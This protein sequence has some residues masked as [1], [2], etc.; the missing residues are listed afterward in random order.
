MY[1]GIHAWLTCNLSAL[2]ALEVINFCW[3]P[4]YFTWVKRDNLDK[5]PCLG[6][7]APS[8]IH[9]HD[10]VI[11][12]Q[13]HKPIHHSA[14]TCVWS[15]TFLFKRNMHRLL[16]YKAH[17]PLKSNLYSPPL[18]WPPICLMALASSACEAESIIFSAGEAGDLGEVGDW[19]DRG[20]EA[21]LST[22]LPLGACMLC[23]KQKVCLAWYAILYSIQ[24]KRQQPQH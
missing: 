22:M 19:M 10:P 23:N 4:I 14:P 5:M 3:V 18:P 20:V 1:T 17:P 7:Y 8:W 16:L 9:T 2:R 12:S 15:V 11:A 13:K 21:S 6:A 24:S